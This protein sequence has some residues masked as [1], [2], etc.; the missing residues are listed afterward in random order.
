MLLYSSENPRVLKSHVFK[1]F[2]F[3]LEVLRC[4]LNYLLLEAT[5]WSLL[6]FDRRENWIW[7]RL[8]QPR[9]GGCLPPE[10]VLLALALYLGQVWAW[11]QRAMK[12]PDRGIQEMAKTG[13]GRVPSWDLDTALGT[14]AGVEVVCVKWQHGPE[15]GSGDLPLMG[16]WHNSVF[17][18]RWPGPGREERDPGR[19][20]PAPLDH[21]KL[22]LSKLFL[23]PQLLPV[24]SLAYFIF[25]P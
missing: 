20:D 11:T 10:H 14:R 5:P 15:E 9:C 6:P 16:R 2:G 21:W 18:A 25:Q 22:S 19:K 24:L 4:Y 12:R 17:K 13:T 8:S 23:R 7:E 1:V 3:L